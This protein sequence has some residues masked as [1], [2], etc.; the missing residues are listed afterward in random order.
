M[1]RKLLYGI[2]F[3]VVLAVTFYLKNGE[4]NSYPDEGFDRNSGPLIYTRHARC[5]MSCRDITENE[6]RFILNNGIV[7]KSKSDLNSKPEPKY[8]VE[9]YGDNRQHLRVIFAPSTR[10]MVVITCIDLEKEWKCD[11]K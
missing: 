9:G 4:R 1:N 8:A 5:R 10:G 7:N 3:L 11:C 2:V 6:I